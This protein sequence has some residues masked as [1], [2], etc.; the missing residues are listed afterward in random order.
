MGRLLERIDYRGTLT[1]D[2]ATLSALQRRF[3][4]R[5]PFENLDIH[6]GRRICL[7]R[8]RVLHKVAVDRRGGWCFELNEVFRVLL[9]ELGFHVSRAAST[10][11]LGGGDAGELHPFDHLTLI[12]HL[13]GERYLS[14]VGF[15]DCALS[16][17]KLNDPTPQTD[18]R[19][20]F[21]I[22]TNSGGL[23]LERLTA[24]AWELLHRFD[25]TPRNWLDCEE[26]CVYLQSSSASKFT[27]KRLCTLVGEHGA[28]TLSGN[29]LLCDGKRTTVPEDEYHSVLRRWFGVELG[30]AE[31]IRPPLDR[32]EN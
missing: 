24:D 13:A 12:V 25:P 9:N 3:I 32:W 16:P 22:M 19:A 21:R 7:D 8:D 23:Q 27:R 20:R 18:G 14:D 30:D 29:S 6:L 28:T 11:L 1:P 5:V 31:W 10:V 17:L 4:Q 26:R 15:G 2:L